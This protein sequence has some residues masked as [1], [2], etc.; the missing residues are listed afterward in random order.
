[1]NTTINETIKNSFGHTIEVTTTFSG[2][3]IVGQVVSVT[4]LDE[5]TYS[6]NSLKHACDFS[7]M[8]ALSNK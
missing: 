2:D 7:E 1:M 8:L 4:P 6:F 5:K 3:R